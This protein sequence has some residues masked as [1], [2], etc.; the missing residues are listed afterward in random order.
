MAKM[1]TKRC[2][3]VDWICTFDVTPTPATLKKNKAGLELY[4]ITYLKTLSTKSNKKSKAIFETV[5]DEKPL[6]WDQFKRT[7]GPLRSKS[8]PS[9]TMLG[10]KINW[11]SALKWEW[12]QLN[13]DPLVFNFKAY[14]QNK[15]IRF[16][17]IRGSMTPPPPP[18]PPGNP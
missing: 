5:F 7:W 14:F 6:E 18:P 13:M 1:T 16:T 15:G 10:T 2:Y 9:G 17:D 3:W 4:L 8:I 12:D 11:I